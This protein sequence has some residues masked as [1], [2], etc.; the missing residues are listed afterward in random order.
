MQHFQQFP[1]WTTL[2]VFSNSSKFLPMVRTPAPIT[3]QSW[4]VFFGT[5]G[6]HRCVFER[7]QLRPAVGVNADG[8]HLGWPGL[9]QRG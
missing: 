6:G 2:S 4:R 5:A 1:S 8:F 3:P 7:H 9:A